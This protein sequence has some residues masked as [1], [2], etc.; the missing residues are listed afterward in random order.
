MESNG[1]EGM[2]ESKLVGPSKWGPQVGLE[3]KLSGKI[4]RLQSPTGV[5]LRQGEELKP[6]RRWE[7][8]CLRLQTDRRVD[9]FWTLGRLRTAGAERARTSNRAGR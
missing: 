4:D 1:G 9:V 5:C 3:M 6:A 8:S 7:H 2:I